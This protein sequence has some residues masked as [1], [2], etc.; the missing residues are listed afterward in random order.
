M[1]RVRVICEARSKYEKSVDR[2][3]ETPDGIFEATDSHMT[4]ICYSCRNC[5]CGSCMVTVD[6][7][8]LLEPPD[9]KE[10]EV[11]HSMGAETPHQRIACACKLKANASGTIRLRMAY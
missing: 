1:I 11:L 2:V 3:V 5:A 9:D 4:P 10:R 8:S 6:D 7:V